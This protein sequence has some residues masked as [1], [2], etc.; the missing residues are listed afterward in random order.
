MVTVRG[1]ASLICA[2]FVCASGLSAR[3]EPPS[4]NPPASVP[5]A[6]S[7]A[8]PAED[9]TNPI[10]GSKPS[11]PPAPTPA[12]EAAKPPASPAPVQQKPA[13]VGAAKVQAVTAAG[14]KFEVPSTWISE[15]PTKSMFTPAA[16]FR[17]PA[18]D[19]GAAEDAS[20]KIFTGIKGGV[21]PNIS[22]WKAQITE[23]AAEPEE[24]DF[25]VSGMPVHTLFVKGTFSAGMMGAGG[26]PKKDYAVLGSIIVI[27]SGDVQFKATGPAAILEKQKPA[28]ETMMKSVRTAD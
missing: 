20:V 7:P 14:L 12:T 6:S 23:H 3:P 16:Q 13:E 22:R 17:I 19:S 18:G 21:G 9:L 26:G 1:S 4:Q 11:K 25:E 8:K 28:W 27:E 5:P 24:K 15:T 10:T 2:L